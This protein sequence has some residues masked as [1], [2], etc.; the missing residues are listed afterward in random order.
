MTAGHT[1]TVWDLAFDPTTDGSR[2]ASCSDDR[3]VKLWKIEKPVNL[4]EEPKCSILA[5]LTG[6][7]TRTI[8]AVDW[9]SKGYLATACADNAI[10]IFRVED[11]KPNGVDGTVAGVSCSLVFEA[12]QAHPRADVNCVRWHPKDPCILASA[13]DDGHV[14]IWR[15]ILDPSVDDSTE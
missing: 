14:R 13:G 4:G 5:T 8:Y 7:H 12:L 6:Y 10:R 1:S 3:T 11:E 15:L 2:F 9:S